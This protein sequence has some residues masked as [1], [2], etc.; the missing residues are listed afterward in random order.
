MTVAVDNRGAT[1]ATASIFARVLVGVDGSPQG[2]EAALQAARLLDAGGTLT[3]LAVYD[4]EPTLV[5]GVG[6]GVPTYLDEDFQREKAEEALRAVREEIPVG[7]SLEAR[8]VRGC[9]WNELVR[10]AERAHD[11]LLAVGGSHRHSRAMGIILG[12]TATAVAHKAS[13]SILI[14]RASEPTFPRAILVGVDGSRQSLLAAEV[15]VELGKR[16]GASVQA[17]AA[18]GAK[19]VD[20]DG[21]A[22]LRR[23]FEA[24]EPALTLECRDN[25]PV[26]ALLAASRETDLLVVGSRGLHGFGALG[27]VSE[28]LA[29]K[30]GCS[31]LIV[32]EP[33]AEARAEAAPTQTDGGAGD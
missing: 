7:I 4:V 32:R 12:S 6:G 24:S 11:T 31:V 15:A 33:A 30:A 1:P 19:P 5:G 22:E 29:Q 9:S 18:T 3:L 8:T 26:D 2:L 14:A 25:A 28:R 13:C 16:H 23:R 20:V 27:S 10:E 21:L 17:L